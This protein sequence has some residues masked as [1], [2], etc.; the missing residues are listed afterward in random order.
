MTASEAAQADGVQTRVPSPAEYEAIASSV[1]KPRPA[2]AKTRLPSGVEELSFIVDAD[3]V[4]Q[5]PVP[6]PTAEELDVDTSNMS[7]AEQLKIYEQR[8]DFMKHKIALEEEQA[9]Q[10]LREAEAAKAAPSA[11]PVTGAPKSPQWSDAIEESMGSLQKV[12]IPMGG[13]EEL[14]GNSLGRIDVLEPSDLAVLHLDSLREELKTVGFNLSK[15]MWLKLKA[16]ADKIVADREAEAAKAT[17]K[18]PKIAQRD[19]R[20]KSVLL[21]AAGDSDEIDESELTGLPSDVEVDPL[22]EEEVPMVPA[23]SKVAASRASLLELRGKAR[24]SS[25]FPEYVS[26]PVMQNVLERLST[27]EIDDEKRMLHL[28]T[29]LLKLADKVAIDAE[30]IVL[31]AEQVDQLFTHLDVD[32][33]LAKG[34]RAAPRDGAVGVRALLRELL[35]S[36]DLQKDQDSKKLAS[37]EAMAKKINDDAEASRRMWDV[38]QG[39]QNKDKTLEHMRARERIAATINSPE[40]LKSLDELY[41]AIGSSKGEQAF[42]NLNQAAQRNH[43]ELATL[44]HH[45]HFPTASS[46]ALAAF[47]SKGGLGGLE[48]ALG[49]PVT[50]PVETQAWV[51]MAAHDVQEYT[52]KAAAKSKMKDVVGD[53]VDHERMLRAALFG[54]LAVSGASATGNFRLSELT[55]P[56]DPSSLLAKNANADDARKLLENIYPMALAICAMHP[57]DEFVHDTM[58]EVAKAC[59]Q[60]SDD[61][62]PTLVN[63]IYGAF[64]R[65]HSSA[66]SDF[67]TTD[68]A[69]P[70]VTDIWASAQ[71]G[72]AIDTA[73]RQVVKK[74][75]ESA[76]EKLAAMTTKI[77][78]LEKKEKAHEERLKRVEQAKPAR[79]APPNEQPTTSAATGGG[80]TLKELKTDVFHSRKRA[81]DAKEAADKAEADGAS[82]AAAKKAESDKFA[83]ELV[84]AEALVATAKSASK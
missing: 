3:G 4:Q 41:S 62:S 75:L 11:A 12:L 82:D 25:A 19:K 40:A 32:G 46:G 29:S 81:S 5:A 67:Q 13:K 28:F 36:R 68:V 49:E 66:W 20:A 10:A 55:N 44:L 77:A 16:V 23:P 33:R 27:Q 2:S 83:A 17:K 37:E 38:E 72:K 57:T 1:P 6:M 56:A 22:T 65:A 52:I 71:E 35:D 80:K 47:T 63:A 79:S 51:A 59:R 69:I 9:A 7:L 54:K 15:V 53:K 21:A 24:V 64:L 14:L 18:K 31:V 78:A 70:D 26:T 58:A 48:R 39:R 50:L 74:A 84:K 60:E 76:Q 45:E 30:D 61:I 73:H 42:L 34:T 43:S 8:C